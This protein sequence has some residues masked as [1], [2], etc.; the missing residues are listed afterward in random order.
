MRR[1]LLVLILSLIA[2]TPSRAAD[3]KAD[4]AALQFFE[5]KIRPVLVKECYS[6][7]STEAPKLKGGLRL[8]SREMM[9]KGGR[10]P[11]GVR[12]KKGGF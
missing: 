9:L 12:S 4:P 1:T 11:E 6:C 2:T 8:D 10:S 5:Q 7:H 3:P